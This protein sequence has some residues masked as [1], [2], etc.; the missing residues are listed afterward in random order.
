MVNITFIRCDDEVDQVIGGDEAA[1][2]IGGDEPRIFTGG[3]EEVPAEPPAQVSD[4][5]LKADIEA[6]GTTV[7]GLPLYQFRYIDGAQRFEGVM[8][9]DVIEK[10]PEAVTVGDDG[11]Y[12]VHYARLGIKMR[13]V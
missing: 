1:P 2:S 11:Y 10:M 8:A 12:R 9:Q 6:V 4:V 3:D 5:R 7:M 13:P